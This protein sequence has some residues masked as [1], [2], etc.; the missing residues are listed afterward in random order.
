MT[1][2]IERQQPAGMI[3]VCVVA[4]GGEEIEDLPFIGGGVTYAVGRKQWQLERPR[5]ADGC[6]VTPL[7][8]PFLMSLQFDVDVLGPEDVNE[9]LDGLTSSFFASVCEGRCEWT[10][11]SSC[12]AY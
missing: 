8:V 4:N 6:L 1:L 3:Q 11:V 2:A 9:T 10:F 7:F 12:K 5:N